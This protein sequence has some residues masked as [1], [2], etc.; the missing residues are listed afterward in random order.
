MTGTPPETNWLTL[1]RKAVLEQ[2]PNQLRVRVA[3]AQD[4]IRRRARELWYAG[5][6]DTAERRR[7]DAASNCLGVLC[8]LGATK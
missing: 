1:Y 7:M 6:P 8:M 3:Q 5:A 2:D 4:A